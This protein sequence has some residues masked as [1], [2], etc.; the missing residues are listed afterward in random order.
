MLVKPLL[1]FFV[2]TF[3]HAFALVSFKLNEV[4]GV[5]P[6]ST[7]SAVVSTELVKLVLA[8]SLHCQEIAQMP[9]DTRPSGLVDSFRRT[10]TPSLVFAT[11]VLS[12]MYTVNPKEFNPQLS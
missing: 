1:V 7:A 9:A 8:T 10:A 6:F 4:D 2:L 12:M 5:Y 11:C 3:I